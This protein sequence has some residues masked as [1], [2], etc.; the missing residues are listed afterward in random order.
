MSIV[1]CGSST[2]VGLD[3][4]NRVIRP[5]RAEP[6]T[7]SSPDSPAIQIGRDHSWL[8]FIWYLDRREGLSPPTTVLDLPTTRCTQVSDPVRLLISVHELPRVDLLVSLF[9]GSKTFSSG[10]ERPAPGE[11]SPV[12]RLRSAPYSWSRRLHASR[13]SAPP[14]ERIVH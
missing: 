11:L 13:P 2:L 12:R 9:I 6:R 7:D 3:S 14:A 8:L 1:R 4:K 10:G 5:D